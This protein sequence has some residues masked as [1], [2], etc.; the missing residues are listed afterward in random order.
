MSISVRNRDDISIKELLEEVEDKFISYIED[1]ESTAYR[2]MLGEAVSDV[3]ANLSEDIV[4]TDGEFDEL[5]DILT[6][7]TDIDEIL[8]KQR[9]FKQ[10]SKN[11]LGY[12]GMSEK[13]FL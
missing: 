12:V 2:Y 11:P 10:F 13:D 4:L 7:E 6:E 1:D 5:T 3:I 9:D 8:E